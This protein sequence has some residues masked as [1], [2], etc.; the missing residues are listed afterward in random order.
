MKFS[1]EIKVGL[2][3]FA[4]VMLL[5]LGYNFLSGFDFFKGYSRYYVVYHN[6]GGVVKSTQVQINGYKVGQVENI[7]LLNKG[8]ASRILV[9]LVMDKNIDLPKGTVA[10]IASTDLL[11]SKAIDIQL[12]PGTE[13]LM[14][15]DTLTGAMEEGLAEIVSPIKEK[16][17]QVLAT[18]DKVLKSMN[19]IFDSTGTEKLSKGVD[20]LTGTLANVRSI[21]LRLDNLTASQEKR[22]EH[23]FAYTE[24]IMQNL[25]NNN[26][27]LSKTFRNIKNITDSVAASNLTSTINNLNGTLAEVEVMLKKINKGEGTFG[28]LANNTELYDNLAK[29][30]K[31]L[32]LLL[33]DM[34][35]YPSRYV[36]VSVFGGGKEKRKADAKRDAEMKK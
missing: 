12:G 14:P 9:V 35:K 5:I 1:K 31:E 34:Q 33:A 2:F 10:R 29:S 21:T 36:H 18:L 16:S 19:R 25:H 24:S 30:S 3:A 27:V 22:L 26:E 4:G 23:I 32:G 13:I 11:G 15:G 17:E 28:Q 6:T 8:D 20:D 7:G